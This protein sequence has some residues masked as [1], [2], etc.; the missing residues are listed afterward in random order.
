MIKKEIQIDSYKAWKFYELTRDTLSKLAK[1]HGLEEKDLKKYYETTD[2]YY[3]SNSDSKDWKYA[4][5]LNSLGNSLSG[6]FF[7]M[8]AHAANTPRMANIIKFEQNLKF[9]N[10]KL[11]DF[12]PIKLLE[13]YKGEDRVAV[14]V[15]TL[16]YN[17]ETGEGLIWSI[18]KSKKH[19]DLMMTRY[20]NILLTSA[21]YLKNFN[22]REE[23]IKDL[24]DHY[25]R[26]DY[27][28]LIKYFIDKTA[29]GQTLACDC[30]KE[31]D[32]KFSF[33]CKPDIHIIDTMNAVYG[34]IAKNTYD[35]IEE[36]RC[37]VEQINAVNSKELITVYRLDKM[38]WLVCS[39]NFY[40]D[41]SENVKKIYVDKIKNGTYYA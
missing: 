14:L 12:N 8:A 4:K 9:L 18:E 20:C 32:K 34:K 23:V 29:Y 39:G 7:Q 15:N 13:A 17:E 22:D 21:E 38:I 40:L 36:M 6:V 3:D 11:C 16:R 26:T 31:M 37:L 33:L 30:L 27:K 19:K 5:F 24:Y 2:F 35:Y 41:K 1:S 10:E 25:V 28:S